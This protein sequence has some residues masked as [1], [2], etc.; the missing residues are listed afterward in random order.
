MHVGDIRDV[1]VTAMNIH[2][3]TWHGRRPIDEWEGKGSGESKSCW[4]CLIQ[5]FKK[6]IFPKSEIFRVLRNESRK[7]KPKHLNVN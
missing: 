7:N 4:G 1:F 5:E 6:T 3:T 2:N